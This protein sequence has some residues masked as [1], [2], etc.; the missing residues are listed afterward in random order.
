M[1]ACQVLMEAGGIMLRVGDDTL[2][3]KLPAGAVNVPRR[4]V[5]MLIDSRDEVADFLRDMTWAVWSLLQVGLWLGPHAAPQSWN[6]IR[7]IHVAKGL[8]AVR[9]VIV[10]LAGVTTSLVQEMDQLLAEWAG[11]VG[12][13]RFLK[14]RPLWFYA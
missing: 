2:T 11:L 1:L 3:I 6:W 7:H 5:G 10:T 8:D 14:N 4:M 9:L 13:L 12:V